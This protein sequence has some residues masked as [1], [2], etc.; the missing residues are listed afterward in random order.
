MRDLVARSA[1][2]IAAQYFVTRRG[3]RIKETAEVVAH[4]PWIRGWI[5]KAYDTVASYCSQ[6]TLRPREL[7]MDLR[8]RAQRRQKKSGAFWDE[9]RKA[10]IPSTRHQSGSFSGKL[11]I[12][13][14]SSS[15]NL[16]CVRR[17]MN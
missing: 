5:S 3:F 9:R 17:A 2:A 12:T 16:A 7:T 8:S 6:I 13:D 15:F 14:K 10:A 4:L 11:S 1:G